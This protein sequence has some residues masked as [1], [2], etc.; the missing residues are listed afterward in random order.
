MSDFRQTEI[1]VCIPVFNCGQFLSQAL[2]SILPQTDRNIEIIVFDGG[3]TDNT[4]LLISNYLKNWPNLRYHRNLFRGGID[5]DL[6][7]CVSLAQGNYC[8]LFSGDDIMRK[9]AI[10]RVLDFIR[11]SG[12]VYICKH[13]I[14]NKEMALRSNEYPIMSPDL[15]IHSD[16]S[17]IDSRVEW[18]TRAVTT[19]AFFSFMSGLIVRRKKWDSGRLIEKFNGSCW[20]HVARLFDLINSGLRVYYV[21]EV[22]LDK[23]GENDSFA[24]NGIVNRYSIAIDGYYKIAD[25][26]FGHESIEAFHI[27]RVIRNEFGLME[28]MPAKLLCKKYPSNENRERL[29]NLVKKVYCDTSAINILQ[30]YL[31]VLIPVDLYAFVRNLYQRFL[32][33]II[34]QN[35]D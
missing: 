5:S 32:K 12:D 18:F 29:D 15:Y 26:F 22:F 33:K 25:H 3:S 31:Y 17:D 7:S 8:W 11:T 28:F 13:S 24:E 16:L 4:P 10:K 19:E 34:E 23:R 1:S 2:D 30:Y 20:G 9:G 21:S 35:N 14:C 6:A 27:R